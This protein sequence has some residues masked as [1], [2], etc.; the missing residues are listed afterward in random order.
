MGSIS[1]K[2][3]SLLNIRAARSPLPRAPKPR[4]GARAIRGELRMT[5]QAG[6]S[7]ELWNWLQDRGWREVKFSPDRRKYKDIPPTHVHELIDAQPE[8]W[9][10]VLMRAMAAARQTSRPNAR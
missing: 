5:L 9:S 1:D 2:V 3:R 8:Q 10:E 6:L 7:D 4:I